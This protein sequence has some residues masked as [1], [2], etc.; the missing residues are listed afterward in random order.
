MKEKR[1]CKFTGCL[2]KVTSLGRHPNKE[3]VYDEDGFLVS[4]KYCS[5]TKYSNYCKIHQKAYNRLVVDNC[6]ATSEPFAYNK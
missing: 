6:F 3:K 5:T 2:R 1:K 4:K